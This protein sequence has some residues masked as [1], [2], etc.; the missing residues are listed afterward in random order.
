VRWL[1][2]IALLCACAVH[3]YS[4]PRGPRYAGV[5][6]GADDH[7][8][9]I[10]VVSFNVEYARHVDRAI[11]ALRDPPLQNPDVVLL[12]EMDGVGTERIAAALRMHYVYY[13]GSI[14]GDRDFGNAVLS[15][16]PIVADRKLLLPSSRTLMERPR[17]AVAAVIDSPG[18]YL[19]VYSVHNATPIVSLRG[20]NDQVDT[21][22]R[23]ADR[24][25]WPLVIGGDFN[26]LEAHSIDATIERFTPYGIRSATGNV[27]A[28]ADYFFGSLRLDHVLVRDLEVIDAGA[29]DTDAS[30]HRAVWVLLNDRRV[31]GR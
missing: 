14:A 29:V 18:G 22:A 4:D 20:R 19:A 15:R 7:D 11:E 16:W 26:T 5:A 30:D 3:G 1:P 23:H 2:I 31:S 24:L 9:R 6:D 13:P 28:T 17:I 25:P 10:L 8:P 21:I 12:Q 27:R